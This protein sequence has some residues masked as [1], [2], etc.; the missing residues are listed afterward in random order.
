MQDVNFWGMVYCTYFA[1]P[2]LKQSRGK[3]IGISS[4]A[5]WLPVP[6]LSFYSVRFTTFY[7]NNINKNI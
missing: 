6:R 1:I 4:S 3:I 2:H 5:A 7:V